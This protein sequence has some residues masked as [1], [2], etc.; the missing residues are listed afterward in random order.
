MKNFIN[1]EGQ[2][3]N[4][5]KVLRRHS[6]DKKGRVIWLCSCSGGHEFLRRG[7]HIRHGAVCKECRR[8]EIESR[9][10]KGPRIRKKTYKYRVPK[11]PR[12]PR[13]P[14]VYQPKKPKEKVAS[15]FQIHRREYHAYS[16]AKN[17]C[18]NAKSPSYHRY[19]G[20]GIDFL[21]ESF[22]SFMAELGPRP[23]GFQLDRI[24]NNGNYEPGNCRWA[25]IKINANNKSDSIFVQYKG[26]SVSLTLCLESLGLTDKR[27]WFDFRLKRGYEFDVLLHALQ[28][29]N[30]EFGN[31]PRPLHTKRLMAVPLDLLTVQYYS[32]P[33]NGKGLTA[34]G[35]LENLAAHYGVNTCTLIRR[36]ERQIKVSPELRVQ[37]PCDISAFEPDGHRSQSRHGLSV[38][39]KKVLTDMGLTEDHAVIEALQAGRLD[40]YK[41][42]IFNYGKTTYLDICRHYGVDIPVMKRKN[43]S[44]CQSKERK[45]KR[46]GY[47]YRTD[48]LSEVARLRQELERLKRA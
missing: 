46:E 16:N 44:Q 26:E 19:G 23:E 17:R 33:R 12:I 6:V 31:K 20:R 34:K 2:T 28:D 14:R 29:G 8:V 5:V 39:A 3:L 22:E 36:A 43:K 41:V 40:P 18:K 42:D 37:I 45:N 35:W 21:Y 47:L 13:P 32:L 27:A 24:D 9:P 38:R 15:L 11:E 7:D 30:L 25:S 10:P 48:L 1:L 4:G